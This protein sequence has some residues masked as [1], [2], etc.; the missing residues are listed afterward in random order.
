MKVAAAAWL[1][2]PLVTLQGARFAAACAD[3]MRLVEKDYAPTLLIGIRTGGLIVAEAMGEAAARPVPILP[4]TCRRTTTDA[5][6]RLPLLRTLL[7]N[8]P[9]PVVDMLRRME[10]RVLTSGVPPHERRREVDQME[11]AAI[12]RKLGTLDAASRVL[13]V[14]DAVD[15]GATLATVLRLLTG[16]FAASGEVRSAAIT[17]TLEDPVIRPD[18][19]LF[20][21]TLCRF[22]WS[23]DA[24]A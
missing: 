10:H 3:L 20:R 19:L 17:Q 15:S 8:L 6:S 16:V 22:P 12:T 5:K 23:F 11:L 7:G 2:P 18:Y 1:G 13:V 4:L 24:A 14:D 9:R 21:R